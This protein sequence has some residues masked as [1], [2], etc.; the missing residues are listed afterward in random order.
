[1][2]TGLRRDA[3]PKIIEERI[4]FIESSTEDDKSEKNK[5][6]IINLTVNIITGKDFSED[7][8]KFLNE[9]L[10]GSPIYRDLISYSKIFSNFY[11]GI[12]DSKDVKSIINLLFSRLKK[13][14]ECEENIRKYFDSSSDHSKNMIIVK[15]EFLSMKRQINAGAIQRVFGH[16]QELISKNQE[17]AESLK[18]IIQEFLE[19]NKEG[20]LKDDIARL[21]KHTQ[22]L[23]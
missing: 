2:Y 20:L 11:E 17:N 14:N 21:Q 8:N 9:E 1:M 7:N 19:N 3:V 15:D 10:K 22:N 4:K 6:S 13:Y 5:E 12:T 23:T 16:V 18:S